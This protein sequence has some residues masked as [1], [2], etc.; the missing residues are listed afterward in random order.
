MATETHQHGESGSETIRP[1]GASSNVAIAGTQQQHT[2]QLVHRKA[3]YAATED[4][5]QDEYL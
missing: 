2:H 5:T 4:M 3:A 1:T